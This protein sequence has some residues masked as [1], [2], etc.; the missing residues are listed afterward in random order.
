[1]IKKYNK[2]KN[3]IKK[4]D[5]YHFFGRLIYFK[6]KEI[7]KKRLIKISLCIFVL[8]FVLLLM[9]Y[10][11]NFVD[12]YLMKETFFK[13]SS[14]SYLLFR[15]LFM[16]IIVISLFY[17]MTLESSYKKEVKR[18]VLPRINSFIG[19]IKWGVIE[20]ESVIN[21]SLSDF[22]NFNEE[23]QDIYNEI[24]NNTI[25]YKLDEYK[26]YLSQ[27]QVVPE[28]NFLLCDDAFEINYNNTTAKI[29]EIQITH[30]Q[31]LK[32][33]VFKGVVITFN[34]PN[35]NDNNFKL[36]IIKNEIFKKKPIGTIEYN[37]FNLNR[38]YKIYTNDISKADKI[39][40]D[41]IINKLNNLY[42]K[43]DYKKIDISVELGNVNIFIYS[44]KNWFDIP[45]FK[46]PENFS[47]Y[48]N[49]IFEIAG[50]IEIVDIFTSNENINQ[51]TL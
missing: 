24:D 18:I 39:I 43:A 42:K 33:I 37:K 38:Q 15:F 50:L 5:T 12:N 51:S 45:V 41:D 1:M 44:D 9:F 47:V 8:I 26:N 4:E 40:T 46:N 48:R 35:N 22:L 25:D 3:K 21:K 23:Q 27:L 7:N 16:L 28:S 17:L 32:Y 13:E 19:N 20:N 30:E 10:G 31:L 34:L 36:Y 11:S 14:L 6:L 29:S 2:I 49:I